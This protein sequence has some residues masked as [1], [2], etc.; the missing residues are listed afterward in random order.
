M[1]T[2]APRPLILVRGFGGPDVADDQRNAYQGFNDGTVYPTKRGENYIYEGF[3]LRALKADKYRYFDATNVVGYHSTAIPPVNKADLLGFDAGE[4]GGTIAVDPITADR[5]LTENVSSSLWVYRYYDLSDRT[6]ETYA[7]GLIRLIELVR[8]SM[9]VRKVSFQ[10]VDIVAHSMGGLIVREAILKLYSEKDKD[11]TAGGL[12]NRVVTL[13]T[14]HR[15]IAFQRLPGWLLSALPKIS[16]AADELKSFAPTSKQF[17]KVADVYSVKRILTIVGTNY[18]TYGPAIATRLNRL[19]NIFDGVSLETNRSDGLVK[20][21]SAQL[22]DAPRT[23]VHKCHGGLDSLVTSRESYEIAMRYFHGSHHVRLWLDKANITQGSDLFGNSEFYF[24]VRIKPRYV[25]FELFHQSP[26]A[27]NCYGPFRSDQLDDP[28]LNNLQDELRQTLAT[29]GDRTTGWAGPDRL[30]WEGW[31]D[32]ADRPPGAEGLVF[33]LDVYVGERDSRGI[34]FS[35][36]VIFRKQYYIQAFPSSSGPKLFVHTG[37]KYLSGTHALTKQQLETEAVE[38]DPRADVQRP[39][40]RKSGFAFK[41]AGTGFSG[42]LRLS[43]DRVIRA[44]D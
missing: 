42:E 7:N 44:A 27:E 13:G 2:Y 22:P 33:R 20:Q 21:A 3:V 32:E 8:A 39:H 30:V 26:E 43:V 11:K 4:T 19:S 34:G 10:G 5:V 36:N 31:I 16:D 6:L 23:F 1:V 12:I 28:G 15:G 9:R 37:E 18:H 29:R 24:G 25:D 35:D 17:L 14:P 40:Q 38:G 41:I